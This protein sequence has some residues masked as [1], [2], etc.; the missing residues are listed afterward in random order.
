[1]TVLSSPSAAKP[2]VGRGVVFEMPADA[3]AASVG[4]SGLEAVGTDED[5][6]RDRDPKVTAPRAERG[7][8]TILRSLGRNECRRARSAKR[9][10]ACSSAAP[11]VPGRDRADAA[12]T[13]PLAGNG[14]PREAAR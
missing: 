9:I 11:L 2:K 10:T 5:P 14:I 6:A 12:W 7:R 1:M 8:G 4:L 3:W 13:T